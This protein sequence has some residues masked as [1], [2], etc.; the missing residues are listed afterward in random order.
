MSEVEVLTFDKGVNRKKSPLLLSGG[1]VYTASGFSYNKD[2]ILECRDAVTEEGEIDSTATSTVNMIH[3]YENSVLASAK[4]LCPGEVAYFN[5]IYQREKD[6]SAF[7][8]LNSMLGS[9]RPRTADYWKFT[10]MVDGESKKAYIDEK[11]Y[12][13]GIENPPAPPTVAVGAAGNP[14]GEYDCYVT[15]H[16]TFP[17]T[18][19][20]ETGPS[21][22]A[23]VTV[24]SEKISWSDIPVCPYSG[25]GLTIYR[26][27]YRSVSGVVYFVTTIQDNTTTTYTDNE[28]DATLQANSAISTTGYDV[29]PSGC[30]DVAMHLQRLFLIRDNKLY[31]SEPYIPFA[32]KPDSSISACR[33]EEDLVALVPWSDQLYIPS[34]YEWYRLQGSSDVT[35]S[36][37]KT[38]TDVG[39]TNRDTLA[40]T[41]F[42][43][44][45]QWYDGVYIFDGAT[46]KNLTEKFLGS[47]YFDNISNP[48]LCY[49]YFDG[50]KY[51]FYHDVG[52]TDAC[53]VIDFTYYPDI[54][55][56]HEDLVAS[57]RSFYTETG[58]SYLAKDGYEYSVSG[59]ETIATDL[60][61]GDLTFGNI[62]KQ[63]NLRYL[64]YD[65]NTNSQDVTVT[66]Y[67]DGMSAH[68]I[69]LNNSART[70]KRHGPLP[71]MDG[72]RFAL[73]IGCS[74]STGIEIYAPWVLEADLVGE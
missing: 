59:T 17:N 3:R 39:I 63:K 26:K 27:L 62:T 4:T 29:P 41:R 7:T 31:W 56:Y 15:F 47:T 52:G 67:K 30:P 34:R 32:F 65:I 60:L 61:T 18:Q 23:T 40:K 20:Y 2:G 16:I 9:D 50:L 21:S 36:I 45:G 53:I 25:S 35:W 58:V 42:G 66:I 71:Q 8:E 28:T 11:V 19:V 72:Y 68:T 55:V 38:F 33:E 37:K 22:A 73:G 43:I 57:A 64:Y 49:A 74:D 10:F 44:L 14:D 5:Y 13:W 69:T 70:R 46:N 24:S 1:E 12:E 51:Y 54:R 6:G 48:E